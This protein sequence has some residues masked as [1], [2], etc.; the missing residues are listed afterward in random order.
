MGRLKTVRNS[1]Q[2]GGIDLKLKDLQIDVDGTALNA[3]KLWGI[4]GGTLVHLNSVKGYEGDP[5]HNAELVGEA[6]KE[7][8]LRA[9]REGAQAALNEA[10]NQGLIR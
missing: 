8:Y 5:W 2:G 6:A 10:V 1:A 7:L 9:Y 4:L 3:E